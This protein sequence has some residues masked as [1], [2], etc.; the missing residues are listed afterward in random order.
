MRRSDQGRRGKKSVSGLATHFKFSVS[1][2]Q[3]WLALITEHLVGENSS[4][5]NAFELFGLYTPK[6]IP[7]LH[8]THIFDLDLHAHDATPTA[9]PQPP[10]VSAPLETPH[11]SS[12]VPCHNAKIVTEQPDLSE[13]SL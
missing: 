5:N 10:V 12:P 3:L 13:I 9:V 7:R 1:G 4:K 2:A 11:C 6:R 8:H